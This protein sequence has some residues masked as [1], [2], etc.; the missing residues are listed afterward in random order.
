MEG[1]RFDDFTMSLST[2]TSRRQA[3]KVLAGAGAGGVMAL[4]SADRAGAITPGRC[5]K[6]GTV[7]RQSA[8]CCSN[9]CDPRTL[10]CACSPGSNVCP[11]T[12]ACV[13]ACASNEVFNPETCRC[14][15]PPAQ[16]CGGVCCA[17]GQVC[18]Q[19][20]GGCCRNPTICTA[21]SECCPGFFCQ[22]PI[23]GTGT[24]TPCGNIMCKTSA[25]CCTDFVCVKGACVPQF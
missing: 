14:E 18:S 9:F 19:P 3:L 23:K 13:P 24:C 5:R 4:V 16:Q 1:S 25:E 6:E 21:T 8:E 7:C 2:A 22:N 10:R 15:C 17:S 11:S 12:G 20:F